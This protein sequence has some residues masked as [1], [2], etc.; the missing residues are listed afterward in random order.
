MAN[1]NVTKPEIELCFDRF[2]IDAQ[3]DFFPDPFRYQDLRLVK[4]DLVSK[5]Y[6]IL[7]QV[8]KEPK[9]TYSVGRWYDWDVPKNNYVVRQGF[10]L[11]PLDSLIYHF[12]LNRLVVVIE[13]KLSN[14]RYSYRVKNPRSK[15]IFGTRRTENWIRF[16]ADIRDFFINNPEYKYLVSTDIA[17]FFE[18]IP[19]THFKKQLQQLSSNR[20]DKAVELLNRMLKSFSASQTCGIPQECDP[21]S[22]LCTAFLDFLDKELKSNSLRHFRYVDDIRVACKTEKDAKIAIVQIIRCLRQVS[23][24][25]SSAKTEI[26][27]IGSPKF[28]DFVRDFPKLLSDIDEAVNL[29]QKTALDKLY[30]ELIDMTKRVMKPGRDFDEVLFR[31][32]LW[33]I[34]KVS[35]FRNVRKLNL[36]AIGQM[37][38]KLLGSM[39]GRSDTFVR[40]LVLHKNRKYVQDGLYELLRE[41]VYPWQE[42]H[43]WE[44]LIESDKCKNSEIIPLAKRRVRDSGYDEAPRNYAIIFLGKHGDYQDRQYIASLFSFTG[45]FRAKRCIII[46]LQEYPE[47]NTIYN[48]IT[49]INSD[50]IL[51]SLVDKIKGLT[52][53]EY[54]QKNKKI[55]SEIA[56]S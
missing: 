40:F 50:L 3:D 25:L 18:Y 19:I 5:V 29:K 44:L 7:S 21:S 14:A 6:E 11:H 30:P 22:Y 4:Q 12:V 47:K 41:S 23:L 49:R 24:N 2:L 1:R 54:V 33:R 8:M 32:C 38:L 17:G 52:S 37:C 13:P 39:P 16:K 53:P 51:V 27:P 26:I 43:I 46:A 42:M 34:V 48:Q 20:E 36:D 45:S 56:V 15:E 35:Y 9:I 55:G 10:S 28:K 31:A